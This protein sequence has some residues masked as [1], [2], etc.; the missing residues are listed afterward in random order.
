MSGNVGLC[1]ISGPEL[2]L[3]QSLVNFNVLNVGETS[4]K[5]IHITNV[6]D[7][8]A[9]YQVSSTQATALQLT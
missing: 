6:S 9:V 3:S 8:D 7:A 5:P 4:T 2:V 1:V